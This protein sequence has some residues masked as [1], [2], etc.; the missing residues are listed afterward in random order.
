MKVQSPSASPTVAV[1]VAGMEVEV[2]EAVRVEERGEVRVAGRVVG[3]R[4]V[5]RVAEKVA[6]R[7][8]VKGVGRVAGWSCNAVG[9]RW[10]R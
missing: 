10:W 1:R 3:V 5:V 6:V 4:G 9:H 7:V 8:E 2:R